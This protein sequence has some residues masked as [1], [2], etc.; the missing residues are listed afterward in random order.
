MA[1]RKPIHKRKKSGAPEPIIIPIVLKMAEFDHKALLEEW[2][3]T[4]KFSNNYPIKVSVASIP[5]LV[6]PVL[7][8][9]VGTKV[10]AL[11]E[12]KN[13]EPINLIFNIN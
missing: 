5:R 12:L 4:R 2:I 13:R 1:E 11:F 7:T 9:I 10:V 3:S 8:K 6:V